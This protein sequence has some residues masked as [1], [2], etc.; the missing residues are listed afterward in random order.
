MLPCFTV[1]SLNSKKQ[2]KAACSHMSMAGCDLRSQQLGVLG[3]LLPVSCTA[4]S[5]LHSRSSCH[6]LFR[7]TYIIEKS[8]RQ[9]AQGVAMPVDDLHR[10]RLQTADM[11]AC[12]WQASQ[13][14]P[15]GAAGA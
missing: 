15:L 14:H 7:C 5:C 13:G 4:A 1:G 6:S 9:A 2:L 12:F 10:L 8:D 11:S 3:I